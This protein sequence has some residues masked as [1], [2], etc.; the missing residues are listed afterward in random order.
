MIRNYSTVENDTELEILR[1]EGRVS[2][3]IVYKDERH[4]F[5]CYVEWLEKICGHTKQDAIACATVIDYK[6]MCIVKHGS[7]DVLKVMCCAL[8]KEGFVVEIR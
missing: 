8:E 7:Y 5:N 6:G 4:S 2:K 3:L 1:D